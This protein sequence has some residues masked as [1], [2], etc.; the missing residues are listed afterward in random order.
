MSD[1]GRDEDRVV[2]EV[3]EHDVDDAVGRLDLRALVAL[4]DVLDDERVEPEG[5]PDRLDLLARR[6]G[7]VDPDARVRLAQQRREALDRLGAARL[8][9]LV[10]DDR[11]DPDR[12]GCPRSTTAFRRLKLTGSPARPVTAGRPSAA[13]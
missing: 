10:A 4:Q 3:E 11:R 2:V 5:G 12:A 6:A 13:G 1:L 7:Q 9:E 8:A